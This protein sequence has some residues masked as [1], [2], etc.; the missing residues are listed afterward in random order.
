[1]KTPTLV[2]LVAAVA[3]GS[4]VACL[5]CLATGAIQS[6]SPAFKATAT[7]RAVVA[8]TEAAL[9]TVTPKPTNTPRPSSTSKPTNTPRPTNTPK[10]THT[11]VT[12]TV[13]P[14]PPTQTPEPLGLSRLNP[15]PLGQPVTA[16]D[17]IEI[18]VVDVKRGAGAWAAIKGYNM[19]NS[20]PDEGMEYVLVRVKARYTGPADST[21]TLSEL[22]FRTVGEMGAIYEPEIFVV[23]GKDLASELFGG[24]VT[25]GELAFQV[26][27][28]EQGLA[29]IYDS[30]GDTRAYYCGLT[31]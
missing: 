29:L 3:A 20:E 13:T 21:H 16:D 9:P 4:A 1:M 28:G 8:A 30:G 24:G 7:V 25:E 22:H 26:V 2:L 15:A 11:P 31:P 10:P 5:S 27:Q 6:L 23:L 18:T 12:P 19:F 17:G 14:L